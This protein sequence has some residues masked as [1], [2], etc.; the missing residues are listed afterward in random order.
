MPV[1]TVD[2]HKVGSEQKSG[3]IRKL[4]DAAAEVT[5]VP[6]QAFV[7]LINEMDDEN[8]GLGGKNRAEAMKSR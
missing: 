5:K 8:I 6:E 1:I 4:T 3:L 7:V 2:I